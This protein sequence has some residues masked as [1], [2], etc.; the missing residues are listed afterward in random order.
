MQAGLPETGKGSDRFGLSHRVR[1]VRDQQG[2][3]SPLSSARDEIDAVLGGEV[4]IELSIDQEHHR[5]V[6][7]GIEPRIEIRLPVD[8]FDRRIGN[9]PLDRGAEHPGIRTAMA[10][11]EEERRGFVWFFHDDSLGDQ[12][13]PPSSR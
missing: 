3:M 8:G 1:E 9:D 12:R 2:D 5:S 10:D 4:A 6:P 13:S 7:R 11:G